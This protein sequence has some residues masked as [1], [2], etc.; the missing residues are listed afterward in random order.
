MMRVGAAMA[1]AR[2]AIAPLDARL[3]LQH[4]LLC[5]HADLILR[6]NDPLTDEIEVRYFEL[7]ERRAAGEPVTKI[8]GAREFY[9]RMFHVTPDVLDPRGDTETIVD[10]CLEK[11]A[12]RILDLG[13]GSGAI[14]LTILAEWPESEGVGVDLSAAALAVAKANGKNLGVGARVDWIQCRWFEKLYG[15]FDL[16]VSNPPYIASADIAGLER[17][18]RDHDPHLALDGGVDG[19]DCY[20][21]I[22]SQAS[23][24]LSHD[25]RIVMEI[26]LGQQDDVVHIFTTQGFRLAATRA[27]LSGI[28]R[29]L[30]FVHSG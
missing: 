20:R 16:I 27:D 8:L 23:P 25:G 10:L 4:V 18:V 22:A 13:V 5:S 15:K 11:R 28:A 2:L 19:L 3:L 14:L 6:E 12:Q 24:F 29:A 1:R 9:G 30:Q 26:G 21:A 7:V 17:D